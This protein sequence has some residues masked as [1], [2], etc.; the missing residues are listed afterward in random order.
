MQNSQ[1]DQPDQLN[2]LKGIWITLNEALRAIQRGHHCSSVAAQMMLKAAMGH[3]LVRVRW[4]DSKSRGDLPAVDKLRRSQLVLIEPGF[5]PSP[6]RAKLRQLLISRAGFESTFM[7]ISSTELTHRL[8]MQ[9]ISEEESRED[10]AGDKWIDLVE[11]VEHVR[12][13]VKCGL[14]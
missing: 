1:D 13:S 11:A 3:G 5:A 4:L 12:L 9:E 6:Y 7:G 10:A 8:R 2:E 14:N